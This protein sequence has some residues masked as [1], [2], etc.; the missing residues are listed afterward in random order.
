MQLWEDA[1]LV[2]VK[3]TFT[4]PVTN[5]TI[6]LFTIIIIITTTVTTGL[7]NTT[8]TITSRSGFGYFY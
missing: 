1:R 7:T 3:R 4:A 2:K 6:A 8:T 5:T